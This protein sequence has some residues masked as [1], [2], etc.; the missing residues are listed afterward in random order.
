MRRSLGRH[1][2]ASDRLSFF[3]AD[4]LSDE[5]WSSAVEGAEFVV[6]AASPMPI[7]EYKG[8]DLI[9]PA[10]EGTLRV[11]RA[12]AT[13][14]VRRAVV[15]SSTAAATG[16]PGS[17]PVD[18]TMWTD[19]SQDGVSEYTRAKTLAERAAWDFIDAQSHS[20]M[21][22][23]T[24]L[25]ASIQGPVALP[26]VSG[27]VEMVFR[28]LKG[29]VPA[30]PRAGFSTVDVRDVVDLHVRAMESEA[31]AGNRF[32]ASSNFL[33]FA[34]MARLLREHFGAR[35]AKVPTRELADVLVRLLAL[36]HADLRQLAPS[37]GVRTTMRSDKAI[38]MLGWHAR[39]AENA[40]LD[41][42]RSL[43]EEGLI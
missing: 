27:S 3:A 6:H 9:T 13:A 5:G 16:R 23:T 40:V 7:R 1:V 42:A 14:G 32:I 2:D 28:M 8:T 15:T 38:E 11:L 21:T 18:E 31:A 26:S 24:I 17:A 36:F 19:V 35:A 29:Y 39:Q 10:R 25:P 22:L 33:W 43:F 4:L 12:A 34:D 41:G 20:S 30:V 37:L